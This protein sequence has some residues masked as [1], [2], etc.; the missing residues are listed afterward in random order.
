MKKRKRISSL[1]IV[2]AIAIGGI[3]TFI[4]NKVRLSNSI[5]VK[6]NR[7]AVFR[8]LSQRDNWKQ[9]LPD[10]D[11]YKVHQFLYNA[12]V[13]SIYS[14]GDTSTSMLSLIPYTN[15]S[16]RIQWDAAIATG[17]NPLTR[18]QRYY[19]ARAINAECDTILQGLKRSIADMKNLY[20]LDIKRES[21]PYEYVLSKKQVFNSYPGAQEV[22][23]LIDQLRKYIVQ[24]AGKEQG[25]PL[26]HIETADSI[27]YETQV[28]IPI[29]EKLSSESDISSKWMMK[30]GQILTAEV[31]G[32]RTTIEK[33]FRQI[34][35]Y[36]FDHQLTEIAIP[37]QSL[38]TDRLKEPDSN[39]WVT[40]L[41]YPVAIY[42]S[43]KP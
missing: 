12:F 27:H 18:I 25:I 36:I 13:I 26:L 7:E 28:A 4:P 5:S 10:T 37:F 40:K 1:F 20:G 14:G 8:Y 43:V 41:Y 22:Y 30:N 38:V 39:R 32:G 34:Q 9:W 15:D 35:Q 21:I 11:K 24:K 23:T 29:A 6:A 3:Y 19:R 2:I 16:L 33:G 42:G 31:T 17:P